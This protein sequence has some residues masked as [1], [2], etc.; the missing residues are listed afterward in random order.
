MCGRYALTASPEQLMILFELLQV[1]FE[2]VPRYNLAPT[3]F[4]PVAH[5]GNDGLR[6]LTPMSWGLVPR[7]A[8]DRSIGSRLINARSETVAEKPAFRTAFRQRRCLVPADGFY[9]WQ[10][11]EAGKQPYFIHRAD[12]SP[13]V[14]AGLWENWHHPNGQESLQTFTIL[15]THSN[16]FL[17]QLHDRM[18]VFIDHDRFDDWLD[19]D[20]IDEKS[21]ATFL[22]PA[23][24][25]LLAMHP[26]STRVNSPTHDEP[27]LIEPIALGENLRPPSEQ[28]RLFD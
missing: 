7:W 23:A 11:T 18:P 2:L 17:S 24:E 13:L 10:R 1:T 16:R 22:S 25:D 15:T 12:H 14:M 27:T 9:E 20:A 26:V 5:L 3:Q 8:K 21:R 28:P 4:A 19:G 6:T